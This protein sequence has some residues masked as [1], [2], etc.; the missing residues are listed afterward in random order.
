[1]VRRLRQRLRSA[2][3][4]GALGSSNSCEHLDGAAEIDEPEPLAESC[5]ECAESGESS[6]AH[7]R[8][9]LTCGHVGCCDSSPLQ[10]AAAHFHRTDHPVMRSAEP[11]EDWRWCYVDVRLA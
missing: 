8:M 5:Q 4:Q 9:C 11:G 2:A 7:L 3:G 6:W 1:M 10:H